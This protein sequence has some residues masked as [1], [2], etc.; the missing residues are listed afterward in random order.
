[1]HSTMLKLHFGEC[2]KVW[3]GRSVR[4]L[5]REIFENCGPSPLG[6][7]PSL[8]LVCPL[9][10]TPLPEDNRPKGDDSVGAHMRQYCARNSS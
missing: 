10:Q 5:F 8:A 7:S 2:F 9:E 6:Q 1:M 4:R 3:H